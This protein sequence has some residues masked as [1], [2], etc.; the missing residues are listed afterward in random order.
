MKMKY[1]C[2]SKERPSSSYYTVTV[3]FA[4]M[5]LIHRHVGAVYL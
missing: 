4:N 3:R 5:A 1:S 2:Y